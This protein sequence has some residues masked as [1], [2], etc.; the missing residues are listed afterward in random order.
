MNDL[1]CWYNTSRVP[2]NAANRWKSAGK[3]YEFRLATYKR[4]AISLFASVNFARSLSLS[5]ADFVGK[6]GS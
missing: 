2:W 5:L 3:M 4:R 1:R 6:S